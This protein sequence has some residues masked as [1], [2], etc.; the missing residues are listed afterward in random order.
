MVISQL[1]NILM[2]YHD[3]MC[4]VAHFR[5]VDGSYDNGTLT[6]IRVVVWLQGIKQ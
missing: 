5:F 4:D 2:I 1:I 6:G 3:I